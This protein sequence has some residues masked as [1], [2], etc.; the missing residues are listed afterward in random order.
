[1]RAWVL[2]SYVVI[3]QPPVR[4]HY[5]VLR[6]AH[7]CGPMGTGPVWPTCAHARL[8]PPTT[9]LTPC[10]HMCGSPTICVHNVDHCIFILFCEKYSN[11]PIK[12]WI[13]FLFKMLFRGE[14]SLHFCYT[15]ETWTFYCFLAFVLESSLLKLHP[16]LLEKDNVLLPPQLHSGIHNLGTWG[17]RIASWK[18]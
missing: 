7:V 15:Q 18:K 13:K 12:M 16:E 10:V 8:P 3:V 9:Q 6:Q 4:Q 14:L 2:H 17:F 5:H 1:M 11:S